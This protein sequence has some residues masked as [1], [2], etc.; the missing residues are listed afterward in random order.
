MK[1]IRTALGF[2][3]L[4]TCQLALAQYGTPE[5]LKAEMNQGE[6]LGFAKTATELGASANLANA[7]FTPARRATPS[8]RRW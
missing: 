6:D 1:L 2:A 3:A 7:V 5:S 4:L 8:C